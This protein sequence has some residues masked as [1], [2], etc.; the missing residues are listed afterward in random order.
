MGC[1]G[2]RGDSPDLGGGGGSLTPPPH[3][4]GPPSEGG[5][6]PCI[7]SAGFQFL[8]LDTPAQLWFFILQYLRGAE[9][10]EGAPKPR[11]GAPK[12]GW[13]IPETRRSR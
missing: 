10:G 6:P 8:L 9:V 12:S 7:T 3:F 1:S 4:R 11:G 5:E 2:F 13:E